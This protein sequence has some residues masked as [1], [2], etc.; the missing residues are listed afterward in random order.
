M[1]LVPGIRNIV[2]KLII[3]GFNYDNN[4]LPHETQHK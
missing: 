1:D 4:F 2:Y 3:Y